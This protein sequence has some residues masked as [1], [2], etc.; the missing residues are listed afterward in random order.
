MPGRADTS[1]RECSLPLSGLSQRDATEH[2][3]TRTHTHTHTCC[4][5]HAFLSVC[6]SV[7][8]SVSLWFREHHLSAVEASLFPSVVLSL[9][10]FCGRHSSLLYS[11]FLL[12][13]ILLKISATSTPITPTPF[14]PS[15]FKLLPHLAF[16]PVSSTPC[17][18]SPFS[19]LQRPVPSIS[20]LFP[21]PALLRA[22][23]TPCPPPSLSPSLISP[24]AASSTF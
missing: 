19:L 11:A 15:F 5:S 21:H 16:L 17:H 22:A 13:H 8:L 7:C 4:T 20:C 1:P 10:C 6:L 2:T 12:P 9:S 23:P 24:A 3:H 14:P 18:H